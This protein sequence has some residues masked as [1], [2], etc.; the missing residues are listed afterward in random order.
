MPCIGS[1]LVS[2][3][4]LCGCFASLPS[5]C[6]T[7]NPSWRSVVYG[8]SRR[9]PPFVPGNLAP[10]SP[11]DH[12]RAP[13]REEPITIRTKTITGLRSLC[14][15]RGSWRAIVDGDNDYIDSLTGVLGVER[16]TS[17]LLA[18]CLLAPRLSCCFGQQVD[19][20]GPA[21]GRNRGACVSWRILTEFRGGG[22]KTAGSMP[23]R[24]RC[25]AGASDYQVSAVPTRKLLALASCVPAPA[26]PV[27]KLKSPW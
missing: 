27:A 10:N 14:Q 5:V 6:A 1:P 23:R 26:A 4:M 18:K 7:S 11:D 21:H 25:L 20:I 15:K 3:A 24:F 17:L 9:H 22:K 13:T 12:Y 8:H 16:R 2:S 19:P